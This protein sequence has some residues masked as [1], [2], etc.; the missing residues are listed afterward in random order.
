M[1]PIINVVPHSV[2]GDDIEE[3]ELKQVPNNISTP[4]QLI[5]ITE[6]PTDSKPSPAGQIYNLK[7]TGQ[8]HHEMHPDMLEQFVRCEKNH[9]MVKLHYNVYENCE[10]TSCDSCGKNV[11]LTQGF[12]HCEQCEYDMCLACY[13]ERRN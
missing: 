6:D 8:P 4:M 7:Q 3:L 10:V 9:P 13:L 12:Y 5:P 1:S 11:D 2:E